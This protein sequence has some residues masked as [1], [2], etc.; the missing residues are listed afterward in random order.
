MKKTY[1]G[2]LAD[3]DGTVY[4]GR[5]LIP[6]VAQ[7]YSN[8]SQKGVKWLFLS[9]NATQLPSEMA[10]RLRGLGLHTSDDQVVNSAAALL[11]ALSTDHRGSRVLV[12]G[13]PGLAQG[14]ERTGAIVMED[15]LQ[16]DLVVVAL[17]TGFTYDKLKRAH[18]ALQRGAPFWATNMDRTFPVEN[19]FHPGAGSIVA[20][21]ATAAGRQPDH[22]FGKPSTD[23][24]ALALA[25]L[26]LP[27][28]SCLVVGDRMETDILFATNADID[29]ALV[30]TGATTKADIANYPYA[31]NYILNSIAEI[32]QLIE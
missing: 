4:R 21:L 22:I 25:V 10:S 24:A 6:G 3:L 30:L 26:G 12:V 7:V 18:I 19:G 17:D 8:M 1:K 2:I 5:T 32:G 27:R 13:E 20:A 9:N 15:P 28:E 16:T 23:M 31:P 29:S 14:V 11:H